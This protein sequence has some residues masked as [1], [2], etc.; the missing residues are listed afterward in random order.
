[1]E[2]TQFIDRV[3]KVFLRGCQAPRRTPRKEELAQV[4]HFLITAAFPV[5]ADF[6]AARRNE[7]APSIA[8]FLMSDFRK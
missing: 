7:I 2:L 3:A 1:M 4:R 6:R 5:G 8:S